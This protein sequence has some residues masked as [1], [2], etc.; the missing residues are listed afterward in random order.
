V[1]RRFVVALIIVAAIAYVVIQLVRPVPAV[2]A[3]SSTATIT[4]PGTSV[5][6]DWPASGEEAIGVEG[7]GL[8][9]SHGA[10]TQT[11][12]A[13]VTKI[14]T[15]YLVLH[16]HPLTATSSGPVITVTPV[17]VTT[18]QQDVLSGDSVVAVQSGE[19]LT[20]LQA[21]EA[22]LL[23]SGDNIA[24]LLAYWDAGS[25]SAFVTEMNAEA[26]RL[27]LTHTHYADASGV[28]PGSESTASDQVRLA[29]AAMQIPIFR[30]IVDMAQ[31]T[32]PVAGVQYNV[33]SQLGDNGIVGIKT[34]Y[35]TAAGGCFLFA[36]TTSVGGTT[37]TVVGAVLHQSATDAHPSA[38]T[39]AFSA[40]QALLTSADHSLERETLVKTGTVLGHLDAPWSTAVALE[41]S[42][43]VTVTGLPGQKVRTEVVL[44][45]HLTA[46]I[47]AHRR[48]GSA[49]VSLGG[50]SVRVPLVT[51]RGLPTA[52]IGWRLTDV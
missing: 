26:K 32:L 45:S 51:S 28:N 52:T 40:S 20:E 33:D 4:M 41:A 29:M 8:L 31:V 34:G 35:T 2:S 12:L 1:G 3:A 19:Q 25:P 22:L 49:I 17:D 14:M 48:L 6:L 16:D 15:A 11:P 7:A 44:P 24:T 50:Q 5:A 23:P 42:R 43:S 46:P 38:L 47:A 13:S 10:Q 37:E 18:Y 30:T 36:A 9:G 21:L 39:N 27:G